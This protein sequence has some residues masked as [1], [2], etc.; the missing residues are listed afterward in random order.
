MLAQLHRDLVR[1]NLQPITVVEAYRHMP[2][3]R[4]VVT[5]DVG[6][7]TAVDHTESPFDD[8]DVAVVGPHAVVAVF[9]APVHCGTADAS[10]L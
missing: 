4:Q 7:T 2:L 10:A 5:V 6:S 9:Q 3:K 1:T 8:A